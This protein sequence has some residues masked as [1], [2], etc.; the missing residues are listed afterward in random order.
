MLENPP[1][2]EAI[3]LPEEPCYDE[4]YVKQKLGVQL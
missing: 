3:E 2:P 4:E 1:E